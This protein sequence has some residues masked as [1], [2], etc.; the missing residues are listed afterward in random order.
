M[1]KGKYIILSL[2]VACG[3]ASAQAQLQ[4]TGTTSEVYEET[5][6]TSTGLNKVYVLHSTDGVGMTYTA[7]TENPVTWYTYGSQGGGYAEELTSVQHDGL[8]THLDQL[9]PN[10]GY[11]IEEGTSR[12]YVWVVNYQDY[13]PQINGVSVASDGS[14]STATVHIDGTAPD[15]VY[16]TINGVATTLERGLSLVYN[17]L[18]WSGDLSSDDDDYRWIE[19]QESEDL[20][21]FKNTVSVSAPTIN[22]TFT[23][24]GDK[25]LE[26]WE[27]VIAV[28]SNL[29]ST[30]AI[31]VRTVVTQNGEEHDNEKK[32]GGETLGDSAPADITFAAYC[33]D[34]VMHKEWQMAED[35]EF[36]NVTLRLNQEVIE[37]TFEEAGTTYWRFYATNADGTCE[38]YSDTYT[39]SIGESELLCPNVFTPGTSEG[40]NDEWKVSYKSIIKFQCTIF[41]KW[42]N[43]I[44]TLT[45]PSQGWDG[46]FH[47]KQ[48]PAGAY[49][50]VIQAEG[51]DGK[52]YK[53]SGDINIIRYKLIDRSSSS[54]TED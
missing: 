27:E 36:E 53:L 11:I 17:N 33:T 47:G 10:A 1:N 7:S 40:V 45:D 54:S 18:V 9:V 35:S 34:E 31:D 23:V 51:S 37:Q 2:V 38:Y 3:A 24:T 15:I 49:Y 50:Y 12:M 20:S 16:Y 21:S 39:V 43:K 42:G 48:C 5:P 4:F 25:F 13:R 6:A 41:N 52:K 26:M 32:S 29:Y 28:E 46:T 22:T 19:Q 8:D 44:I 14:C 30:V